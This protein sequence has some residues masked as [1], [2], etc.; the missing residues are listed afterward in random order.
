VSRHVKWF[1]LLVLSA[2]IAAVGFAGALPAVASA[3]APEF[4]ECAKVSGKVGGFNNN[5]C[6]EV[7]AEHKGTYE[8]R[9]VTHECKKTGTVEGHHTG[10]WEDENCTIPNATHEGKYELN[11]GVAKGKEF[12]GSTTTSE[13]KVNFPFAGGPMRCKGSKISG[14]VTGSK[15]MDNVVLTMTSCQLGL[16]FCSSGSFASTIV[17]SPLSGALT[18]EGAVRLGAPEGSYIAEFSCGGNGYFRLSGHL[19]LGISDDIEAVSKEMRFTASEGTGR[20]MGL[21]VEAHTVGM[22]KFGPPGEAGA[23]GSVLAKGE[24]LQLRI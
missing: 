17:T 10:A 22:E 9:A 12:S 24:A 14:L 19:T 15:T 23:E 18:E 7:N 1:A 16:E 13:M 6:S 11:E 20:P 8:L 4:F 2:S 5:L 3:S 21:L